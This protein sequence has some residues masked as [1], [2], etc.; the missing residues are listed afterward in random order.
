[1]ATAADALKC[2]SVEPES[3]PAVPGTPRACASR[4]AQAGVSAHGCSVQ[5]PFARAVRA[6]HPF[7]CHPQNPSLGKEGLSEKVQGCR[8][9]YIGCRG[10][11]SAL[12]VSGEAGTPEPPSTSDSQTEFRRKGVP[13]LREDR[14]G[15]FDVP[16]RG[17][18]VHIS[19]LQAL[20]ILNQ[21]PIISFIPSF[22]KLLG[23]QN[24]T[25][26]KYL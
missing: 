1:M 8:Q 12:S 23:H 5:Q 16:A 19:K 11:E 4:A 3:Q 21:R 15:L 10:P 22:L 18:S 24:P 20:E 7:K 26:I 6:L 25:D 9:H 2:P 13:W 14:T 17:L